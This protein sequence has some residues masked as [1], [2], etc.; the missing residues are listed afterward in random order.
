MVISWKCPRLASN[1]HGMTVLCNL[2]WIK[3]EECKIVMSKNFV[4]NVILHLYFITWL[5][6]FNEHNFTLKFT[7]WPDIKC[8]HFHFCMVVSKNDVWFVILHERQSVRARGVCVCDACARTHVCTHT[9]TYTEGSASQRK[10]SGPRAGPMEPPERSPWHRI[11]SAFHLCSAT[12]RGAYPGPPPAWPPFT[13][14]H[15]Q[16]PPLHNKKSGLR[17]QSITAGLDGEII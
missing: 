17:S 3:V 14:K 4:K 9:P 5:R 7:T 2:S 6:E 13:M 10:P 11:Q 8:S 12:Q 1:S 16:A 15:S